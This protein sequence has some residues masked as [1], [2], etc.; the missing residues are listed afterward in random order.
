MENE[1]KNTTNAIQ[2][3]LDELSQQK[4]DNL[5]FFCNDA[6]KYLTEI[7][8]KLS[9]LARMVEDHKKNLGLYLKVTPKQN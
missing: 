9:G 7:S 4:L 6:A 5:Q 1:N 8:Q 3:E 2:I